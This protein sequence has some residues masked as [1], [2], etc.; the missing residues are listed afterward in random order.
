M[1]VFNGLDLIKTLRPF[2]ADELGR[3]IKV[4]WNGARVR[5]RDRNVK[6]DGT[7]TVSGNSIERVEAINFWNPEQPLR[8]ISKTQL[9]WKSFTTGNVR[10]LIM[11][12]KD[13]FA[14]K[15]ELDTAQ[16]KTGID[17]KDI[18]I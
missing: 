13:P 8:Q 12:L 16:V 10:G 17:I 6:W 1:D 4:T 9:A 11:T 3:R 18:G 7:L 15:I 5:G 14:G 2:S